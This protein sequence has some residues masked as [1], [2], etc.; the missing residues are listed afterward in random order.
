MESW[1]EKMPAG[2]FLKS[3]PSASSIAAPRPGSTLADFC[4]AAGEEP[5]VGHQPVPI[6]TFIRYGVWFMDRNVPGVERTRV[7]RVAR[8]ARGFSVVLGDGEE[9]AASSVIVASGLEGI[10]HM[11]AE[12]TGLHG[13][14]GCGGLGLVSH[15]S[16]HRDLSR[17]A[18]RRVGVLGA[19]QSALENAA[20]LAEAGAEVELFARGSRVIFAG[21]P[22]DIAHQGRGTVLKPESPLGPGWSLFAFSNQ[23]GAFRYLPEPTRLWLVA[24]VLGPFGAWWLR[25]RVDD[26]VPVHLN[27]RLVSA[28]PD[29]SGV[30]LT[31][32]I[33]SGERQVRTFDHVMAATGY[34]PDV[35]RLDL[36]DP[37]LR[38]AISRTAGTWPA[39]GRSFNSS[40]GGLY[41]TGLAAAATFGPLMRFVCGTGFAARR[42]R[43]GVRSA[44]GA[45]TG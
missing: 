28:V 27:H 23:A 22:T 12:L 20:L 9:F 15:S 36:L 25:P 13:L 7:E 17:F 43:A 30:Q 32:A 29:G 45:T 39:L 3:T 11:P 6:D 41:F 31:F 21:P 35:D 19:G 42:V 5:L 33:Q 1:R 10:A 44:K 34:R 4:A 18:G 2:M 26:C 40:V 37:G 8:E 24:K 14:D 38:R 16:E